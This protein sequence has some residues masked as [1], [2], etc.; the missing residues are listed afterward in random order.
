MGGGADEN[1]CWSGP[2]RRLPWKAGPASEGGEDR[3]E[4]NILGGQHV[5]PRV[6][7]RRG[8]LQVTRYITRG[9]RWCGDSSP[10]GS[11]GSWRAVREGMG[12]PRYPASRSLPNRRHA[13]SSRVPPKTPGEK[14]GSRSREADRDC[15]DD[16]TNA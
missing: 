3:H 13:F 5:A 7:V 15:P 1:A 9:P 2:A 14:S 16:R 12:S 4:H 6:P 8:R 10:H 11:A